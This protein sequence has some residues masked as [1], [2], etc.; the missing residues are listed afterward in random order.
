MAP[1]ERTLVSFQEFLEDLQ[2]F[3]CVQKRSLSRA[4]N[5]GKAKSKL[6][7]IVGKGGEI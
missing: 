5:E 1:S 7:R 6:G 4:S 3:F 2:G